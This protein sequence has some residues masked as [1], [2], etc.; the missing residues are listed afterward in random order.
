[1]VE[2]YIPILWMKKLRPRGANPCLN[3]PANKGQ[4]WVLKQEEEED[5]E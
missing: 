5:G 2:T 1:M 3:A 4:N